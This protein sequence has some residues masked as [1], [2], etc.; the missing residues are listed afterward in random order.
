MHNTQVIN[1]RGA[2]IS[3]T[4]TLCYMGLI[5]YLSSKNNIKLPEFTIGF[6]KVLHTCAYMGLA[7]LSYISINKSGIKKYVFIAAFLFAG[8]YGI[9]D[10]IHQSF[11]P[12]RDAS[13]GDLVA[14]FSGALI[15]CFGAKY[16][17]RWIDFI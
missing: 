17:K 6:D 2:L 16:G 9:S 15:G 5:Y 10:E 7:F 4:L 12:G 3:W 8:I 14:D 13:L 11:V 1:V